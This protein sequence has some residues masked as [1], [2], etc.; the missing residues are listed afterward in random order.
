MMTCAIALPDKKN[1]AIEKVRDR[2]CP[3]M[4]LAGDGGVLD[5][6]PDF[7]WLDWVDLSVFADKLAPDPDTLHRNGN[8][9]KPMAEMV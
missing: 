6:L 5:A 3:I 7:E 2:E 8:A 4:L 9:S 1:E